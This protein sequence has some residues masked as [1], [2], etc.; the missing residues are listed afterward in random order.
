VVD[1]ERVESLRHFLRAFVERLQVRALHFVQPAHLLDQQ[2]GVALDAN[3]PDAMR[4]R[5]IHRRDKAVIFR[6]VVREAPDVLLEFRDGGAVRIANQDAVGRRPRIAAGSAVN[7]QTVC[8][9]S[10]GLRLGRRFA[11]EALSFGS[12][13]AARHQA[14]DAGEAAFAEPSVVLA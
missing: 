6:D 9:G 2:L 1:A 3:G 8:G 13:R 11:E 14:M 4:L 10:S 7:V 12:G 5:V